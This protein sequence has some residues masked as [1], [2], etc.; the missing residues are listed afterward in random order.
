MLNDVSSSLGL[1]EL[2]VAADLTIHERFSAGSR[3][4]VVVVVALSALA[5]LELLEQASASTRLLE[6]VRGMLNKQH[7]QHRHDPTQRS[8]PSKIFKNNVTPGCKLLAFN[9]DLL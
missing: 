1:A 9:D 5:L 8:S 7:T 4:T 2:T 3:V 6:R